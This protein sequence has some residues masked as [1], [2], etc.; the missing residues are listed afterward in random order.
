MKDRSGP[1]NPPKAKRTQEPEWTPPPR[2]QPTVS[3]KDMTRPPNLPRAERNQEP[4]WT[5]FT[6]L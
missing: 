6:H 1:P 2:I 5:R 4:E 3:M